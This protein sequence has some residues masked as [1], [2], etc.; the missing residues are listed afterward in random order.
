MPSSLTWVVLPNGVDPDSGRLRLSL[1][2]SPEA[3]S[4]TG[5]LGDSVLAAWPDL[6]GDLAGGLS[7]QVQGPTK[8]RLPLTVTSDR[9][10]RAAWDAVFPAS[11]PL[12]PTPAGTAVD[13]LAPMVADAASDRAHAAAAGLY[14]QVLR[15]SPMHPLRP[16]HPVARAV[17]AF[18]R[19]TATVAGGPVA[20]PA[21]RVPGAV[22]DLVGELLDPDRLSP[23]RIDRAVAELAAAGL[24]AE[25]AVAPLV[26][27][28]ARQRRAARP[29]APDAGP[30]GAA[31]PP[32]PGPLDPIRQLFDADVHQVLGLVGDHP[33]VARLLGLVVDLE[34]DG[35]QALA[36][37]HAVRVVAGA[38]LPL[39]GAFDT[40]RHPW[41]RVAL[42]APARRF[43]MATAPAGGGEVRAGQLDLRPDGAAYSVKDLDVRSIARQLQLLAATAAAGA[44]AA[45]VSGG[46]TPGEATAPGPADDVVLPVRRDPGLTLAQA[47]RRDTVVA[48]GLALAARLAPGAGAVPGPGADDDEPEVL[49]A[50]DVTA[51]YRVDV[52]R[53]GRPFRSLMRRVATYHLGRPATRVPIVEHDE[54]LVEPVTAVAQELPDGT[55][56]LTVGDEVLTWD[57]WSAAAPLPGPSVLGES[58][59]A[60]ASGQVVGTPDP[61]SLKG[62]GLHMATAVEPGS[63]P[64]LRYGSTYRFRARAVDLAGN[65][66]PEGDADARFAS[67]P[68]AFRRHEPVRPPTLV[69]RHPFRTSETLTH[70]VVTSDGD[71][72]PLG[73][74]VERHLAPPSTPQRMAERHGAFDAAFGPDTPQRAAARRAMLALGSRESGS[75]TD[76]TIPGPDGTP[77]P[78][79]GLAVV[80]PD[81]DP[82]PLPLPPG[83]ALPAGQYVVHDTDR[84]RVPYLPDVGAS[85]VVL[86]PGRPTGPDEGFWATYGTGAWPDRR[87][88]RLVVRAVTDGAFDVRTVDTPDGQVLDVALAP[89]DVWDA[90]VASTIAPEVVDVM[91]PLTGNGPALAAAGW[92]LAFSPR[93]PLS[94]VHATRRPAAAPTLK[95]TSVEARQRGATA[96]RLTAELGV[97]GP[98]SGQ[99]EAVATWTE[100][101]DHGVG[102]VEVDERRVVL[103]SRTVARE[104]ATFATTLRHD[105]GDTRRRDVTLTPVAATRFR[106]AFPDLAVGDP[107]SLKEGASRPLVVKNTRPPAPP[108][109]HSVVPTYAWQRTLVDGVFKS[110][111]SIAGLRVYLRRPWHQTGAGETLGVI[112]YA[113]PGDAAAAAASNHVATKLASRISPDPL[114][115]L[116]AVNP[117]HRGSFAGAEARMFVPREAPAMSQPGAP[118]LAVVE[119]EV[120]FDEARDLWFADVALNAPHN[121]PY[122]LQLAVVRFNAASEKS[123]VTSRIVRA[124]WVPVPA[125]QQVTVTRTGPDAVKLSI[126]GTEGKA[127]RRYVAALEPRLRPRPPGVPKEA[128]EMDVTAPAGSPVVLTI[129]SHAPGPDGGQAARGTVAITA[130][131]PAER[132]RLAA[133]RLVMREV[134]LG[135][136]IRRPGGAARTMWLETVDWADLMA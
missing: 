67:P 117:L 6:V 49:F 81:G 77:V 11:A 44:A 24:D 57:G 130:T 61:G 40:V 75:F 95:V 88:V 131:D 52:S 56:S 29:I 10:S 51:G 41:S 105:F 65:S 94:M 14:E 60:Q 101:T 123:S 114:E 136:D 124:D 96:V 1:A 127:N 79:R 98:T 15:T 59:D 43:V 64:A 28:V 122:L 62:Y 116:Q 31:P 5:H 126:Q 32:P 113:S 39:A 7:L 106:D 70:L 4:D 47:G 30:P 85:G 129:S 34:V 66:L 13:A 68:V 42:D 108:E 46:R 25:A 83:E 133:G 16:D 86:M 91:D 37:E 87:P 55:T 21:E 72:R 76:P 2:A 26:P 80:A 120:H 110:T 54:G 35:V 135:E 102:P 3:T 69:P 119:H 100:V 82:A 27:L 103:D 22:G 78:V 125:R 132:A 90:A 92:I 38:S 112:T 50:D 23:E 97:H 33:A 93:Q 19:L 45:P 99:V 89:G 134:Q 12:E 73:E 109:V 115:S 104:D 128:G 111:R 121:D 71:G 63:L 53:D 74:A 8:A 36:G 58:A 84:L 9:P 118:G 17:A 48:A 107:R 20:R 18:G